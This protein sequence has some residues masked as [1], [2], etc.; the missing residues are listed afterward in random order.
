MER[1]EL[2]FEAGMSLALGMRAAAQDS[3]QARGDFDLRPKPF[4][5]NASAQAWGASMSMFG[6]KFN[7]ADFKISASDS[8]RTSMASKIGKELINRGPGASLIRH[9]P[10]KRMGSGGKP[11]KAGK[12]GGFIPN[13]S[14][15]LGSS[16]GRELAAG[17]PASAIRV[18]SSSSL[19]SSGNPGGLGV[20]NTIDEPAGLTQGINRSRSAGI[21]PKTHGVPNFAIGGILA[22]AAL[23]GG[24]S[25]LSTAGMVGGMSMLGGSDSLMGSIAS[26]GM[27][28]MGGGVAGVGAG[29]VIGALIHGLG[30]LAEQFDFLGLGSDKAAERLKE[31]TRAQNE[32]INK[33]LALTKSFV[34]LAEGMGA[35]EFTVKKATLLQNLGVTKGELP[36]TNPM[37]GTPELKALM[38][39]GPKEFKSAEENYSKRLEAKRSLGKVSSNTGGMGALIGASLKASS[40]IAREELS[41]RQGIGGD[42]NKLSRSLFG[43]DSA[44]AAMML[45]V[46]KL[47]NTTAKAQ[48]YSDYLDESDKINRHISSP[49]LKSGTGSLAGEDF[50]KRLSGIE[51]MSPDVVIS[52]LAS[53]K[54]NPASLV[55]GGN[56]GFKGGAKSLA[57]ILGVNQQD[58]LDNLRGDGSFFDET[59]ENVRSGG[60]SVEMRQQELT[61]YINTII[62][63]YID[64]ET[65]NEKLKEATGIEDDLN[66]DKKTYSETLI[67]AMRSQETYRQSV[68][69]AKRAL[70]TMRRDSAHGKAMFGLGS[71]L[72]MAQANARLGSV[73]VAEETKRQADRAAELNKTEAKKIAEKALS[74][75]VM[76]GLKGMNAVKFIE[77]GGFSGENAK[78]A[79]GSFSSLRDSI[80]SSADQGQID[81]LI[82]ELGN[83]K[84]LKLDKAVLSGD[85]VGIDTQAKLDQLDKIINTLSSSQKKYNSAM[86]AATEG[87]INAKELNIEQ[88]RVTKESI[89]VN[90]ELNTTRREEQRAIRASLANAEL[91]EA[92]GLMRAGKLGAR[93]RNAA[94]SAALAADVADRGVQKGDVGRAFQAGFINE[95]DYRPVDELRDFENGSRQVAQTMK[96]SFADAFS[97]ITSGATSVKGA[98]ANMAQSILDSISQVSSNMFAN[99]MMSKMAGYS[100]GGYV[101]GYNSGG[102]ITGGSGYKDDV[103]IRATGGEFVIKKSAV[104]KIGLPTL[105]S[106]NGMANGGMSMGKVGLIAAGAGAASGVL[107]AAMQ[108]GAPDV[109]RSQDYGMGRSKHGYLGGA[110]P[111][112]RGADMISGGGGRAGVSLNKAYTYYRRDPQ[113]GQLI[114]ERAR[115]TE[116]RFEVSDNLSLLGRLG[117]DDPQ[118][119]RMFQKEQAMSSYQGYLSEET[120]RRKAAV[121]AVKRQKR[122][123][124]IQA[125]ANAA[126]LIGGAHMM[127]N[128]AAKDALAAQ[129][130]GLGSSDPARHGYAPGYD[131]S[132]M[133][134]SAP[135]GAQALHFGKRANGGMIATMGGEYIMSPEAVRTHGI[136]FMTELNRGNVPGYASG[137]LVGSAPA[138]GGGGMVDG[139]TTNNVSINVN[140][141]KNGKANADSSV[142]SQQGG[143]SERD[144]QEEIENNKE[145]GELLQGVV[146]QEIVKQQRPGGLLNRGTTGIPGGGY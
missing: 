37:A 144:Q 112:A 88:L 12:A 3:G 110:D 15:P 46:G 40:E 130:G 73:G 65:Y 127:D 135:Q 92:T 82:T 140:I 42:Q 122:G 44:N 143:P 121:K 80:K 64:Q 34:A 139:S 51:G 124:L 90:Y 123:R 54:I 26:Y 10:G 81:S 116:G 115:P 36:A 17:V 142:T 89:K 99:M 49:D 126:M 93:D 132:Q 18:G 101:Q 84:G 30:K 108:P 47:D 2:F 119:A 83:L 29:A 131:L 5:G 55:E 58:L 72:A 4:G 74:V 107:S 86:D 67:E 7:I 53:Q 33:S 137:G 133:Q 70:D 136:N 41:K 61:K 68:D 118:T 146:L 20:Y 50:L 22:R 59:K 43:V 60:M 57:K 31:Q 114:S 138:A 95:F 141:D 113:T 102:L 96:S 19:R 87:E 16:V 24:G 6:G 63:G 75:D 105:N 38:D 104:N 103:P 97:S 32:S 23:R 100:Q 145:F 120:N 21:N 106:I 94:F 9:T 52:R 98:L 39:A 79:L 125:Y 134:T 129:T 71:N 66:K 8:S 117:E 11:L 1:Q 91:E 48:V 14:S 85:A 76:E 109:P 28:G 35:T 56:E 78:K 27:M 77:G 128:M 45:R 25:A 111:D 13:F 69:E 62:A